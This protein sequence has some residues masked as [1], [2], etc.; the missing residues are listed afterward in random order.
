MSRII[1]LTTPQ[2]HGPHVERAQRILNLKGYFVGKI[3]GIFGEIT[4]RACTEAKYTLGYAQ[5]N[6]KP[7]YGPDLEA[8]L[9]GAKKPTPLMRVRASQRRKKTTLGEAAIRVAREYVGMKENPPGSNRVMFSE[10]YGI[11]GPWCA[12]FVT[13]CFVKA[14]SKA[15]QRGSRWSYCPYLLDDARNARVS[16]VT[17]VHEDEV[18]AGDVV[19]YSWKHDGVA[20]HVGIVV[21]PPRGGISFMAIEGNTGV[22]NDSNGG[23]VMTRQRNIADV[24]GFVRVVR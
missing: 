24:I 8:F 10:W 9:T 16:G 22:G 23:E 20:D 13:Y 12:M 21:T 3:D 2:T 15:F 14:G 18:R 7:S 1:T 5:K 6:I 19:L 11:I 4:A 17:I